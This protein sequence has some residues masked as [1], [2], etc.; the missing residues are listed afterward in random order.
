MSRVGGIRLENGVLTIK[1]YTDHRLG[2]AEAVY[3][4]PVGTIE[5]CWKYEGEHIVFQAE[6]PANIT[7]KLVLPNG[8]AHVLQP[9]KHTFKVPA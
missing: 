5:S 2:F 3:H 7:A 9:G 1:P 4:S 6:V 8:D